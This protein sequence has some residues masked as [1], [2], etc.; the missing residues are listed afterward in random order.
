LNTL[1]HEILMWIMPGLNSCACD[2]SACK[3]QRHHYPLSLLPA[4]ALADIQS[5]AFDAKVSFLYSL[6]PLRPL[7]EDVVRKLAPCFQ[8]WL[9][10]K[11]PVGDLLDLLLL[12][13]VP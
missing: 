7:R 9:Q 13:H 8:V 2:S 6:A 4:Q 1:F 12:S 5:E 10:S 3:I 11:L